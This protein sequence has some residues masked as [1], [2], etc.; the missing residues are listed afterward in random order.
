MPGV[1]AWS[2]LCTKLDMRVE[3]LQIDQYVQNRLL[4]KTTASP[5]TSFRF[6]QDGRFML[7][8]SDDAHVFVLDG[9]ASQK[10]EVLGF[11]G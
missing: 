5:M 11:V 2:H 10:F 6:T 3:K 1:S 8:G 9:R 7:T 4:T